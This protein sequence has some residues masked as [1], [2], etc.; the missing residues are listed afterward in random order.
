MHDPYW[1]KHHVD[2]NYIG[3]E[4]IESNDSKEFFYYV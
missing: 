2:V 4:D 3:M 1:Y